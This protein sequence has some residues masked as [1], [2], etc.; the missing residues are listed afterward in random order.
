MKRI[1]NRFGKWSQWLT[2]LGALVVAL[3]CAELLL[4]FVWKNPFRKDR[5]DRVVR[6]RLHQANTDHP[7]NRSVIHPE[8]PHTQ[9]RTDGRSYILPSRQYD[10]P[11][12]TVA[13]FGGSTTECFAVAEQLRF[14]A[15]VSTLLSQQG[16]R[17]STLNTGISGNTVHDSINNLLNHVLV[18]QPDI[19]VMMHACNDIGV[20]EQAGD[21]QTRQGQFFGWSSIGRATL[22]RLTNYWYTLALVRQ[23]VRERT[24]LTPESTKTSAPETAALA[25]SSLQPADRRDHIARLENQFEARVRVFVRTC[26]AFDILP[27][28]VTQPI[29]K[30][31]NELTPTWVNT[32]AQHRFNQLVSQVA[33]EENA[34]LID[35]VGYLNDNFTATDQSKLFYDGLHVN[36]RGSEVYAQCISQSLLPLIRQPSGGSNERTRDPLPPIAERETPTL[37]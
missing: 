33:Q 4:R 5:P 16:L 18:D 12:R 37:R 28:L 24:Y 22:T 32:V 7:L 14:P 27:V 2:A 30:N 25:D 8:S 15:H 34:K 21:Y 36:D 35:L 23:V 26:H 1:S 19:A 9:L 29:R 17:V 20:L 3:V 11:D 31:F 6:L 10:D 13:F